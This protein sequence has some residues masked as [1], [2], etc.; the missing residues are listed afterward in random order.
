MPDTRPNSAVETLTAPGFVVEITRDEYPL[1]PRTENENAAVLWCWHR[2]LNLGDAQGRPADPIFAEA[3]LRAHLAERGETLRAVLPLY[4]YDH[5]GLTMRTTPFSCPFD[6]GQVGWCFLTEQKANEYGVSADEG[7]NNPALELLKQEVEEYDAYLQG[8]AYVVSLYPADE[9][10][11][12]NE[13]TEE[14]FVLGLE[15][16]QTQAQDML[17]SVAPAPARRPRP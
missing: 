9:Q 10:G 2:R 14:R 8:D 7:A 3:D 13:V 17:S 15:A 5:S 1:N 4:L 11:T 16:A 6:S 12:R